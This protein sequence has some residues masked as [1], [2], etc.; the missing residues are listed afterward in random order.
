[1]SPLA[2]VR[3]LDDELS[4]YA[5]GR[6]SP[7][8]TLTWERHLAVCDL[9]STALEQERRLRRALAGAP[10]MPGDLHASLLA[11]G[12]GLAT[13]PPAPPAA[14]AGAGPL[15]VLA[16]GAPPCHR[17]PLRATVVA[18]AAAGVSAAA[19]WSLGVVGAPATARGVTSTPQARPAGVAPATSGP[20]GATA[21]LARWEPRPSS[22]T[23]SG[24]RAQ[25]TP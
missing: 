14:P 17:S 23:G 21:V 5:A 16:P 4:E 9:C 24:Q 6:L 12:R 1:M 13:D 18:A 19:A 2:G 10:S 20:V 7:R 25:S 3:C 22:P 8:R 15:P 11:M